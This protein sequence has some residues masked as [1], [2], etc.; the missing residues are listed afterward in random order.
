MRVQRS[1]LQNVTDY[2]ERANKLSFLA[3]D[4]KGTSE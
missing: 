4:E 3:T 2:L 1:T